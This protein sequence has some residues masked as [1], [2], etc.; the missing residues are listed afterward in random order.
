MTYPQNSQGSRPQQGSF[1]RDRDQ[2]PPI[3]LDDIKFGK[4][5]DANLFA[6]IAQAKA[7]TIAE[8]GRGRKNKSTQLR[9]FY[10]EL[11]MWHDKV[12]EHGVDREAKYKELAP[13]IKMLCAKV[14]YAKGRDHVSD[15]FEKL[16]THVIR[17]INDSDTLKQAKLFIEAFM[18][19][20][21]AVEEK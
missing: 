10:D 12:F 15:G 11:V 6:D 19:F 13:F 9:K 20:Y 18:G 14:A 3:K 5:I 21:K 16:F 17:A 2:A 7:K 1:N 8:E 4:E